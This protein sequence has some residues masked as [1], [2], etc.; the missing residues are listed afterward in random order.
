MRR[1]ADQHSHIAKKWGEGA[2]KALDSQIKQSEE[3]LGREQL[4]PTLRNCHPHSG[5]SVMFEGKEGGSH[6]QNLD[7][8]RGSYKKLEDSQLEFFEDYL[9]EYCD[10][11]AVPPVYGDD[12][13]GNAVSG[14]F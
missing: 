4:Y 3:F 8:I 1:Q 9:W 5:G 12:D 6:E 11:V 13:D 10:S 7:I 2:I 14:S